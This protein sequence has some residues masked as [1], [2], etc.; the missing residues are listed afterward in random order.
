MVLLT[1][2]VK[3]TMR[4][5]EV[6]HRLEGLPYHKRKCPKYTNGQSHP[7]PPHF[8]GQHLCDHYKHQ[9]S[10]GDVPGK[11]EPHQSS[12]CQGALRFIQEAA[13]ASGGAWEEG[14]TEK[15]EASDLA[16]SA[17]QQQWSTAPAVNECET[18]EHA[19][20]L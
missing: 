6:E 1:I 9:S 13:R 5:Y 18:E 11:Y 2:L 3:G 10:P 16:S 7:P 12:H 14:N 19:C 8:R 17:I 4:R 15:R 20:K